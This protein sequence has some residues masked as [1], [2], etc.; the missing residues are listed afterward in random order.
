MCKRA[1]SLAAVVLL[2][3]TTGSSTALGDGGP[4]P[5]AV[6]GW[7]GVARGKIRY[8]AL[9]SFDGTV[10]ESIS[11]RNG[12][13]LRYMILHGNYGIPQVAFDGTT[14]GLS[15][16]GRTLVL[17]QVAS[18]PQLRASTSFTVVDVHRFRTRGTVRISGDFS[19]DAL[20]P[21]ARMLY[22]IEHVSAQN[23]RKYQVRAYDLGARR[24]LPQVVVDK[25][26]W[27]GVMQGLPFT[28]TTTPD[29]RWVYTLYGG[30]RH[31]FVHAL[32]TQGVDAVCLDLPRTWVR[33][34]LRALRLR[35]T[36]DGRLLV[37]HRSGGKPLAILDT[38]AL[39]V[40]SAVP[41][42]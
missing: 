5:G 23:V 26:S 24:L 6:Q 38:K 15:R 1:L 19:F 37:R 27:E 14:G 28:R 2:C 16:D 12:R 40:L 31:P 7:D 41:N 3:T 17:E 20:S 22:L 42:P 10:L 9:P 33:V 4:G 35:L 11:R 39:R 29:G 18:S 30:G 8:V 36:G 21:G 25:R 32:D 34:N 13:V